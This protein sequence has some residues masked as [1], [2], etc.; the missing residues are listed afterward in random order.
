[1]KNVNDVLRAG[2]EWLQAELNIAFIHFNHTT[3]AISISISQTSNL[4]EKDWNSKM[5]SGMLNKETGD[6]HEEYLPHTDEKIKK[7]YRKL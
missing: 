2:K 5:R 4:S 1:M 3:R 7:I 6:I